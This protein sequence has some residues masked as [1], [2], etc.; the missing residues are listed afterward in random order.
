MRSSTDCSLVKPIDRVFPPH[1]SDNELGEA[2]V[3]DGDYG[4]HEVLRKRGQYQP[5]QHS[6]TIYW[7]H[8]EAMLLAMA[9]VD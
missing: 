9:Q 4:V 1:L 3:K 7:H 5:A 2:Y 6:G 8:H